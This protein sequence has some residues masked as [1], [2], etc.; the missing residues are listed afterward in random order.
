[1]LQKAKEY[2]FFIAMF[3]L[4]VYGISFLAP[5]ETSRPR[6][7]N[8]GELL[9]PY[10]PGLLAIIKTAVIVLAITAA[11]IIVG[12]IAIPFRDWL[13][14][15]LAGRKEQ[16]EMTE[17]GHTAEPAIT[18]TLDFPIK[19]YRKQ[20]RPVAPDGRLQEELAEVI[21]ERN[22]WERKYRELSKQQVEKEL[23]YAAVAALL[24]TGGRV[25]INEAQRIVRD[26][27]GT[28]GRDYKPLQG[29]L[30][31]ISAM[32]TNH[33]PTAQDG[34]MHS[35]KLTV[36]RKYDAV[37]ER[38]NTATGRSQPRKRRG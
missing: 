22:E 3:L 29:L 10:V 1:M 34:A 11:F 9:A 28:V 36:N 35:E 27:G 31:T 37:N 38:V 17:Q 16:R 12:L 8:L 25:G 33:S 5:D 15:Q 13:E 30:L 6:V 18:F 20:E 32:M 7:V 2:G 19:D 21:R 4:I 23:T 26:N 14:Y 24:M